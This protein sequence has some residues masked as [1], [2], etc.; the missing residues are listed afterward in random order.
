VLVRCLEW[1]VLRSIKCLV[2]LSIQG[3]TTTRLSPC[4]GVF[5]CVLLSGLTNHP[6]EPLQDTWSRGD[7]AIGEEGAGE[8]HLLA[9][10]ACWG[11]ADNGHVPLA[12]LGHS[13]V[14]GWRN[15]GRQNDS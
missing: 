9:L 15:A 12:A 1:W 5:L 6:P 7:V 8:L 14:A 13:R 2:L 3:S 11:V 10:L 4:T